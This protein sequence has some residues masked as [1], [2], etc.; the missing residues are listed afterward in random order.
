MHYLWLAEVGF[1]FVLGGSSALCVSFTLMY[2]ISK[3]VSWA[4]AQFSDDSV[5][6]YAFK[7]LP[8]HYISMKLSYNNKTETIK[9]TAVYMHGDAT[10][11]RSIQNNK[12][13][14]TSLKNASTDIQLLLMQSIA[15]ELSN[16]TQ[17]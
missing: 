16:G 17:L 5:S 2:L 1:W 15:K 3:L 10:C 14:F 7:E 6:M 12:V 4:F 13:F 8:D 9:A 11:S